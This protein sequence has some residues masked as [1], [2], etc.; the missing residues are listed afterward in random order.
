MGRRREKVDIR[1]IG[2]FLPDLGQDKG[3]F[4]ITIGRPTGEN[5]PAIL[6]PLDEPVCPDHPYGV[7]EPIEP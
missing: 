7:L 6:L 4:R 5:Q 3:A 2:R 1:I